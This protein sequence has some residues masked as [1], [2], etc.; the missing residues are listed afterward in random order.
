MPMS[1]AQRRQWTRKMS[2]VTG[3]PHGLSDL[4]SKTMPE[5]FGEGRAVESEAPASVDA[6]RKRASGEQIP[7]E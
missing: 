6:R 5:P 7:H 1:S 2:K 3:T 4:G